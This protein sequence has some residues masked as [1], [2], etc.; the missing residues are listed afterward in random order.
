MSSEGR[1]PTIGDLA[2]A[3]QLSIS[4]VSCA[5]N[6]R[7]GVSDATRRRVI[8]YADRVGYRANSSARALSQSRAGAI[9][10][11]VRESYAVVGAESYY[12]RFLAGVAPVLDRAGTA[13]ILE[14]SEGGI[15]DEI[16]V[17]RRWT[18]E[19]R[20]DG[21][22]LLDEEVGD[23]RVPFLKS[24]RVPAVVHGAAPAQ[25]RGQAAVLVDETLDAETIVR[26]LAEQGSHRVLHAVGPL[27][28]RHEQIR[29]DRVHEECD[30]RGLE[31]MSIVGSYGLEDGYR[32]GRTVVECGGVRPDALIAAN[33]LIAVGAC[34]AL[35]AAK[36][37]IPHECCVIAWDN[38]TLCEV[39]EPQISALER[40]PDVLGRLTATML[41]TAIDAQSSSAGEVQIA[42]ASTLVV[43]KSTRRARW[44]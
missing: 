30:R 12:L 8:E 36:V 6:G 19:K 26:H 29:S 20:V 13:L 3:L 17:Y 15:D 34:R 41:L 16:A 32:A 40:H 38:S 21:L 2:G 7:D 33:D 9:G 37:D 44:A 10:V 5:L 25:H 23:P 1:S 31:Y 39:A 42:P 4:S 14:L 43:R 24:L 35:A 27:R 11:V 22:I 28:H 18:A